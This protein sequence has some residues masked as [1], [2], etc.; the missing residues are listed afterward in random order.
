M[1]AK[2]QKTKQFFPSNRSPQVLQR[3]HTYEAESNQFFSEKQNGM[4]A[5][6]LMTKKNRNRINKETK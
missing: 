6:F 2:E 3:F 1:D 4:K 5:A